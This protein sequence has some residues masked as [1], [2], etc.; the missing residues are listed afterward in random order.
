MSNSGGIVKRAAGGGGGGV[1]A[2]SPPPAPGSP[3]SSSS[4]RDF[5]ALPRDATAPIHRC[6]SRRWLQLLGWAL[7][8]IAWYWVLRFDGAP[9]EGDGDPRPLRA[10]WRGGAAP[11][12]PPAAPAD[13]CAGVSAAYLEAR[14]TGAVRRRTRPCHQTHVGG[15]PFTPSTILRVHPCVRPFNPATRSPH[16]DRVLFVIMTGLKEI[17]RLFAVRQTWGSLVPHILAVGEAN[18]SASGMVTLDEVVPH[19]SGDPAKGGYGLVGKHTYHDAQHRTLFGLRHGARSGTW[20]ACDWIVLVD[21]DTY[22][23]VH[24]LP[25]FLVGWDPRLP[26]L[27]GHIWYGPEMRGRDEGAWPSGGAGIILSRRAA[28]L[29]AANLYTKLCPF[30]GLNDVTLGH[31]ATRLGIPMVRLCAGVRGGVRPTPPLPLFDPPSPPTPPFSP[32][33]ADPLPHV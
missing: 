8:L 33:F 22:V 19:E 27:F 4:R 23:N 3:S 18:H 9:A 26:L 17:E 10:P 30:L 13:K 21:D 31:C 2:P 28:D 11:P 24:E 25:G 12:P 29:L 6:F 20:K 5:F 16:A 14:L 15:S 32:S 1:S 7:C